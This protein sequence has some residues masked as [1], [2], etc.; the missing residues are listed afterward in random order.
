MRR[1]NETHRRNTREAYMFITPLIIG[2]AVFFIFPLFFS[3]YI[4]LGEFQLRQGGN[5]FEFLGFQNYL[6]AFLTDKDFTPTFLSVITDSL[7]NIPLIVVF[8]LIIAILLNKKFKGK[9]FFRTLFFLPFLLGTGYVMRQLL[10]MDVGQEAMNMARGIIL[11]DEVQKYLGTFVSGLAD[12]FLSR[13]TMVFWKSGV[14]IILFLSGLQSINKSLYESASVDGATEWE[15]MWKITIPMIS[16]MTL[17]VVVY[18]VIESFSDPS[19]KMV[20]FFYNLAFRQQEFSYSA[21]LSWIYF[22]FILLL[23]GLIFLASRRLTY[24]ERDR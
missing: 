5:Q 13:I 15:M 24:S 6:D 12:G 10:G 14:P 22:I 18:T 16:Q 1:K 9:G 21:A 3:I 19:N 7:L 4:S 11:P 17:L 23:V 8:S 20:D 2:T